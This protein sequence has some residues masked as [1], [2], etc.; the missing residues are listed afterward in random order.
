MQNRTKSALYIDYV[1]SNI[2]L[3]RL[4]LCHTNKTKCQNCATGMYFDSLIAD[5]RKKI[6]FRNNK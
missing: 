2:G 5:N 6:V 1:Y 3:I 4:K